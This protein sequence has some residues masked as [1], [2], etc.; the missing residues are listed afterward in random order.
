V[1]VPPLYRTNRS[2][3]PELNLVPVVEGRGRRGDAVRLQEPVHAVAAAA[4][5]V[6]V[7]LDPVAV[8]ADLDHRLHARAFLVKV[9]KKQLTMTQHSL[10]DKA[11]QRLNKRSGINYTVR[12]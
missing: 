9:L 6:H 2:L 3:T 1:V 10:K 11:K 7:V 5:V 8:R 12:T 4:V